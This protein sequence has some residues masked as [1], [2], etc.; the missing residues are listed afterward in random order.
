MLP[1]GQA[2]RPRAPRGARRFLIQAGYQVTEAANGREALAVFD[3]LPGAFDLLLTDVVMPVMGGLAL[4]RELRRR[5]PS[6]GVLYMSGYSQELTDLGR[7]EG[8]PE[9]FLPK[10]FTS[11]TLVAAVAA[12]LALR[13]GP[14]SRS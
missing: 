9:H 6:L 13:A 3:R 4:A 14:T 5:E 1:S 2:A 12:A 11:A 7:H 10:P 8:G